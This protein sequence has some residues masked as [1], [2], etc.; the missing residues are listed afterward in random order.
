M[1]PTFSSLAQTV[2]VSVAVTLGT[3]ILGLPVALH[4]SGLRPFFL[5]FTVN[6]IAQCG[7]VSATT[8]LLQRAFLNPTP[9]TKTETP[10]NPHSPTI[11]EIP[12]EEGVA[13]SQ[14]NDS[15]P[16][17]LHSLSTLFIPSTAMRYVFN[18]LVL[19]HFIFVIVTYSLAGP[20]AF[21]AL[22]PSLSAIPVSI[23]T[24]CFLLLCAAI[25]YLF[26]PAILP[27]LSIATFIKGVL[28]TFL[29]F[30][31]F[32][33]GLSIRRP[34]ISNWALPGLVDPFLMSTFAINGVVHLMPVT[35]QSCL[36]S[37]PTT[38]GP[39]RTLVDRDF[40]SAYRIACL[41]AIAICYL[42][43]LAWCV[44]VLFVV[45]QSSAS[46]SLVGASTNGTI[47]KG[48]TLA[49]ASAQGQISTIP[50][51]E[52]LKAS[53]DRLNAVVAL[54]VN[55]FIA[56]SITVSILVMSVG[57][58]HF[59]EGSVRSKATHSSSSEET[60]SVD[61]EAQLNSENNRLSLSASYQLLF[62]YGLCVGIILMIAVL[63]PSG[64]FKIMEGVTT[65]A[66]NLEA[67]VF[68]IYM[69]YT[70]RTDASENG[71]SIPAPLSAF[72]ARLL[73]GLVSIYYVS[74]VL[75]D[76]VFYIP[77]HIF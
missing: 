35:F 49:D 5:I 24:T 18:S 69:F 58:F 63:N 51:I 22:F 20:Q 53:H 47:P 10:S 48:A 25:V 15:H 19:L 45:P 30:L 11:A 43:N 46:I 42:L 68:I 55:L 66:L 4:Q 77:T 65:L 7:I 38:L 36:N 54:L 72:Y 40:I 8:E 16:P 61:E 34:S 73:V 76:A 41:I 2:A 59:I 31:T 62:R 71:L 14:Q 50:L 60:E 3:G 13:L 70:S 27:A 52:V 26:T 23:A 64:I 21:V 75:I 17:S 44:A 6:F 9:N 56:L 1:R 28:L 29:I 37:L 74:A 32:L 57:M 67:G 12:C 33:R 39:R